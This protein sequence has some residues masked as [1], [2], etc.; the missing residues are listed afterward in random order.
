MYGFFSAILGEP[1]FLPPRMA[2]AV[3]NLEDNISVTENYFLKNS[4]D[5]ILHGLMMGQNAREET[6]EMN[7]ILWKSLYY[8][9]LNAE[10][11]S[12]VRSVIKQV[13]IGLTDYSQVCL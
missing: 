4:L 12:H 10:E 5:D 1:L 9:L 7:E 6:S 3:L 2:H 11:R 13:E 8:K